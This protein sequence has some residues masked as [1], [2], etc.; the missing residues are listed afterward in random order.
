MTQFK[1]AAAEVASTRALPLVYDL[2]DARD[3]PAP[4]A[5]LP[6]DVPARHVRKRELVCIY[7]AVCIVL[8]VTCI[9][10]PL[11]GVITAAIVPAAHDAWL[12]LA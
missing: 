5:A 11:V 1:A 9:I 6:A 12:F 8:I 10:S 7:G 3:D 4:A 2:P